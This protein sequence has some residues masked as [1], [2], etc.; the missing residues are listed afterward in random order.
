MPAK[1]WQMASARRD[2]FLD[3]GV[4]DQSFPGSASKLRESLRYLLQAFCPVR[5]K[6]DR[7]PMSPT[8][9]VLTRL[10]VHR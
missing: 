3:G 6:Y 2:I 4:Y 1:L 9:R 8:V 10:S 7:F 5:A